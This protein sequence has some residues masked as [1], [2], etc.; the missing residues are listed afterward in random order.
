MRGGKN[1]AAAHKRRMAHRKGKTQRRKNPA[2]AHNNDDVESKKTFASEIR[3]VREMRRASQGTS[4][5]ATP[6]SQGTSQRNKEWTQ[7]SSSDPRDESSMDATGLT[8]DSDH[9]SSDHEATAE[10]V[11]IND[12]V[13]EED[14]VSEHQDLLD[15]VETARQSKGLVPSTTPEEEVEVHEEEQE[16]MDM[17]TPQQKPE[18]N[19]K[20]KAATTTSLVSVGGVTTASRGKKKGRKGPRVHQMH[21]INSIKDEMGYEHLVI[22]KP[23]KKVISH[24]AVH[25]GRLVL[26]AAHKVAQNNSHVRTGYDDMRGAMVCVLPSP[27]L[28]L[29]MQRQG[30][31]AVSK[32]RSSMKQSENDR[33]KDGHSAK[34]ISGEKRACLHVKLANVRNLSKSFGSIETAAC[35]FVAAVMEEIIREIIQKCVGLLI[36]GSIQN[37]MVQSSHIRFTVT[38]DDVNIVLKRVIRTQDINNMAA[39]HPLFEHRR[40]TVN[41]EVELVLKKNEEN[42]PVKKKRKKKRAVM[43]ATAR[44][45]EKHNNTSLLK[46]N[47]TLFLMVQANAL[48]II[49]KDFKIPAGRTI[50]NVRTEMFPEKMQ[51]KSRR[52]V[53]A[54][55]G[56]D[57]LDDSICM[58][59]LE[60]LV[61]EFIHA[62]EAGA[63]LSSNRK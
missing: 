59:F 40:K 33:T 9:M 17:E 23:A 24:A 60:Y 35:V 48:P 52:D 55:I 61:D 49:F 30:E 45:V 14:E 19:K 20:K 51:K 38:P 16:E 36:R 58:K 25:F 54:S 10:D 62:E 18:K 26:D 6:S 29:Q 22:S 1:N 8:Q 7:G 15:K 32:Y 44:A 47:E 28:L 42:Q 2:P 3:R 34:P 37:D 41:E 5:E 27:D 13:D 43:K 50:P 46:P 4:E 12:E 53:S 31:E 21:A 56:R 57:V 11:V 39:N 63:W